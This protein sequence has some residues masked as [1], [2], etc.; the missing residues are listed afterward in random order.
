MRGSAFTP[1]EVEHCWR[2]ALALWDMRVQLSPPAPHL[3]FHPEERGLSEPLAYIDLVKR[4][5]FVNFELL[6]DLGARD[7]LTAVLAH[8]IGHHVRFPHTLGWDA[9]LRVLEQRLLP[10]LKQSLTNL[11]FDL[12]VNEY[13]GRTHAPALCAVY[14]GFLRRPGSAPPSPLFCFYLALY[15]ELWG[16]PPGHL[17]PAERLAPLEEAYPGTRAEARV[18][19]Q[20]FYSLSEPREQF[21]YFCATFIRY[22]DSL[23]NAG[24]TLPLG[25][26]IPLPDEADLDAAVQSGGR[27][28]D[29]LA[30][31]KE[32][33]WL[34]ESQATREEDPLTTISR[35]TN[36]L[37]GKGQGEVRRALVGRYYRRLVDAHVLRL[38]TAPTNPEPSLRT[39]P[40]EWEHGDDPSSI[41]WTLTV[42]SRGPLAAV[43][44]LRRDLEVDVPPA[45]EPGIPALELYLDT[46]G[47]MPNPQTQL[48]AMTLAAQVLSA[49][50]LRKQGRVR[51]VVYSDGPP[52]ESGWMYSEDTAREFLLQ[53][54]GGGTQFPIERLTESAQQTPDVLRV[55]ISDS[56]FLSN[57]SAPGALKQLVEATRRS[58][59]LVVFLALPDAQAAR[60]VFAPALADRRFRLVTVAWMSDF[61][62]MAAALSRALLET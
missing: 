28:D 7:S 32:R 49:S 21:L 9:E 11:Y 13:V 42:L 58:R 16:L 47:S 40:A 12:Q 44:P 22:L 20:T 2:E 55:L 6:V 24:P 59:L 48:N 41:D 52:L 30:K 56:D 10:G 57:M 39:T 25:G 1:E 43:S 4:Q 5:V 54:I 26:D 23:D 35:A 14:Q 61:G 33:G 53:F 36:H 29:A 51:A 60:R 8:E 62:P 17:V 46:S 15:E 31:A 3:P 27:W 38:P 19:A 34:T 18:F 37:P 50:A 45:S